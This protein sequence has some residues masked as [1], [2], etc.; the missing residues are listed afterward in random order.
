VV[1]L[2]HDM[3]LRPEEIVERARRN[4]PRLGITPQMVHAVLATPAARR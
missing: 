4:N 1:R 3:G 2:Y